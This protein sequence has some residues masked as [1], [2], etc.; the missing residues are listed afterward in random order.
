M[1]R[2][3]RAVKPI[4][5]KLKSLAQAI[6]P[7]KMRAIHSI[8]VAWL[9]LY[10]GSIAEHSWP[11]SI[12]YSNLTV[13]VDDPMWISELNMLKDDM[14]VD[15]LRL[16]KSQGFDTR[17]QTIRFVNGELHWQQDVAEEK[18]IVL[19]IDPAVM[20]QIDERIK[21]VEDKALKQALRTYFIKANLKPELKK[22]E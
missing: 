19:K 22:E 1:S 14:K 7:D 2:R 13:N 18:E 21:D 8:R 6:I 20:K 5:Y 10:R 9:K 12:G 17:F 4:K 15:L 11:A 3:S 16:L